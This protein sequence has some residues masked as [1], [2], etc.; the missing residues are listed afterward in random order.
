MIN[1]VTAYMPS[2]RRWDSETTK[3]PAKP[4]ASVRTRDGAQCQGNTRP[5]KLVAL[6]DCP[7]A[8][9]RAWR[10]GVITPCCAHTLSNGRVPKPVRQ[11]RDSTVL[12]D[13]LAG[14]NHEGKLFS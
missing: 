4:G 8:A 2:R 11:W 10:Y 5:G 12:F 1:S 6:R 9:G 14:D 13:A 3:P 7:D